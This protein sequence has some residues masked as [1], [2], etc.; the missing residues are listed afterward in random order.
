MQR[1]GLKIVEDLISGPR[2]SKRLN[3]NTEL[4]TPS[5]KGVSPSKKHRG[6]RLLAD[7][8]S[9][10]A[11]KENFHRSSRLVPR[12]R[13]A[14]VLADMFLD[15]PTDASDFEISDNEDSLDTPLG[16]LFNEHVLRVNDL[17]SDRY[18]FKIFEDS[19]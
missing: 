8:K 12:S 15:V 1:E 2:R 11:D 17:N 3:D 4:A 18:N 7:S 9:D 6:V 16:I 13:A 14:R 19:L 10:M 5:M